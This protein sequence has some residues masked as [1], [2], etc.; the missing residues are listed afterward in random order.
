MTGL[1]YVIALSGVK[2]GINFTSCRE[3]G[4][5]A[6]LATTSGNFT[7]ASAIIIASLVKSK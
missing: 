1:V 6:I 3:N 5:F 2:F 4:N 7:P